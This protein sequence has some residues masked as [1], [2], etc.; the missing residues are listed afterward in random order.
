MN[1]K[2]KQHI[3]L[4]GGLLS[5][6]LLFLGTLNIEFEWFN[7]GSINAFTAVLI[8]AIPFALLIYGVYKNTY[9]LTEK[10]KKQERALKQRGLK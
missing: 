3:G 8:A 5:A 9:L 10:A 4:F 2:L 6:I 1:D 7:T